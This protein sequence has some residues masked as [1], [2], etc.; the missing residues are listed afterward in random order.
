MRISSAGKASKPRQAG[1]TLIELMVVI[2][3]ASIIVGISFPSVTSGIDSLRLNGASN[4][5]VAFLNS[6]LSRSERRQQVVEVT[7]SK[8]EN[9]LSMRS[10]EATFTRKLSMPEGVTIT[11]I[12]PDLPDE[13]DAPRVFIL[14]PG[15]TVPP[16]GVWLVNRRHVDRVVQVDPMTGVAQISRPQS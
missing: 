4:D 1:V 8:A 10:S 16:L 11:R 13:T 14:Y 6:G 2:T 5:I 12:L 7:I 9:T 15:G 3:I